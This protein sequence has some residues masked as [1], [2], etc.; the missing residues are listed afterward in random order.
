MNYIVEKKNYER[1]VR[2]CSLQ[3]SRAIHS[4]PH[5]VSKY[6]VLI[7]GLLLYYIL[8]GLQIYIYVYFSLDRYI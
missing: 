5:P 2:E 7:M 4:F 6:S 8:R 3:T 1:T